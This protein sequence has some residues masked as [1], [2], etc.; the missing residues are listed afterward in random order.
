[1]LR[2][3][4]SVFDC[5]FLLSFQGTVPSKVWE[6][7]VIYTDLK[8]GEVKN[9]ALLSAFILGLCINV[10]YYSLFARAYLGLFLKNFIVITVLS[11]FL[12][13]KHYWGGGD[14]KLLICLTI[15]IPG[16]LY[17]AG[18]RLPGLICLILVFLIAYVYL[19]FD[20]IRSLIKH[21]HFSK[22]PRVGLYDLAGMLKDY[23]IIYMLLRLVNI[24][25]VCCFPFFYQNNTMIVMLLNILII[26]WI[27]DHKLLKNS[28]FIFGLVILTA[29]SFLAIKS[30]RTLNWIGAWK[31]II[32][33]MLSLPLR[34]FL[35]GYNYQEIK[36]EE[37]KK[38]MILSYGTV[39][40]FGKSRIKDLPHTTAE[41]MSDRIS[42]VQ[43]EAIHRWG[44]SKNGRETIVIV[45]KVPFAIFLVL[46]FLIY[47]LIRVLL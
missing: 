29:I 19:L 37:A 45:K 15:L 38:G 20:S 17:D 13:Y 6:V 1:M 5:L 40:L 8:M 33:I 18:D 22:E 34:Y 14:S 30:I 31:S 32:A 23:C 47:V 41:D 3:P 4:E 9:K 27:A 21:E 42:D 7:L 11:V 46:G 10:I 39:L 36:T 44:S 16:R 28:L 25:W 2:R 43:A 24:L 26:V 35:S 12:Y